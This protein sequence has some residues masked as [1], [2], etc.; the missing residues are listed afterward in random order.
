MNDSPGWASPGS[1]PSDEPGRGGPGNEPGQPGQA[2]PDDATAPPVNWSKQ[3]PPAGQW[4]APTGP[5]PTPPPGPGWGGPGNRGGQSGWG[6][7]WAQPPAAAKP[8]IIPLRPLGVGEILDG[9]VSTMRA[10]WRTVLGISLAVAFVIQ[11]AATVATGIWFRDSTSLEGL[12]NNPNPSFDET[13]DALGGTLGSTG[14]TWLISMLGTIIATAMLTIVVSRAV[15]GRSVSIAEAWRHS[16]PQLP[17]LFGLLFLLPLLITAVAAV[18]VA[19]GLI[20]S[21]TGGSGAGAAL[22]VLGALAA[23][24]LAIWLWIRYSLAA[25]ALMLE[26]QGVI[27]SLRR[28]AKLVRGS[29]WR[30]CGIQVL[31]M[32]LVFMVSAV[33]EIPTSIVATVVGGEGAMDWLSGESVTATWSFLVIIGI[34]AVISSTITFP[35]SAGVTALLY[36]D[37]RIRREA[38]DL[39]LARAAGIPEQGVRQPSAQQPHD[40]TPGS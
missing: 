8:G 14:V 37:Q 26:K 15:L 29:W 1:A 3:Q 38:L 34:G 39:E 11:T 13:M 36:M 2:A 25:P 20:V 31:T 28:S 17:R 23:V 22:A 21:A 10:H 32:I 18:A 27:A 16:R 35:I 4:A 9:A 7:G 33:I 6:N 19:P 40:T 30:I 5:G 12:E 24:P